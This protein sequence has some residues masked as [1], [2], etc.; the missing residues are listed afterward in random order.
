MKN[1]FK[2]VCLLILSALSL[3]SAVAADQPNIILVITDD[4]GYGDLACHGNPIIQTPNID[5][6]YTKSLRLTDYHVSPTCAPTRGALMCGQPTDKAGPWHTINGRNYMRKEKVTLP[7]TLAANGYATGHFGK[8]HLGDN[9]PY[10]PHDRGFQH[11]FYHGGGGVGQTPDYFGNDYNDDTYFLNGEPIKFEGYCTDI[12]FGEAL[13][14]IE[15]NKEKPFFAYISTNSPHSPFIVDPKYSD[16]YANAKMP[17][18]AVEAEAADDAKTK[19]GK[20]KKKGKPKGVNAAFYGMI[21]N[22]DENFGIMEEKLAEWGL[23]DNTIVIF[24]TDNGSSAGSGVFNAGMS[25]AKGSNQEGG[26][27]VP[28]FIRWPDGKL[29]G[30]KDITN[31]TAHIDVMPTLLDLCSVPAPDNYTMDG[32]TLRPLFEGGEFPPRVIATDSQRIYI[33]EKWK[34]T[35]VMSEHWRL[36]SGGKLYNI[37]TDPGQKTDVAGEFPEVA[38][39]L[40][41]AYDQWW[42]DI[43][44]GFAEPTHVIVGTEHENPSVLTSHDW[45]GQ[46]S[47]LPW[48]QGAI[49]NGNKSN[50]YWEADFAVDGQYEVSLSRWPVEADMAIRDGSHAAATGMKLVI[51]GKEYNQAIAEGDKRITFKMDLK[52]GQKRL[53]GWITADGEDI[54][55][56]Y[57]CYINKL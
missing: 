13:K 26:H 9:Y 31:L 51:D 43:E 27:R 44:P 52:A 42:A 21:T 55:G 28:F 4:Q 30:G 45:R 38:K 40:N 17:G 57:Y 41:D 34:S 18:A 1:F 23:T 46:V 3:V 32:K 37:K 10:R 50:G 49:K 14:W 12:W 22:I 53:Q 5:E 39:R 35:S 36:L 20:A 16:L 19:K 24:T 11:A 48:N 29:E 7:E 15:K 8:W 54:S 47:A 25:G 56:P 33:P 2:S 6:F